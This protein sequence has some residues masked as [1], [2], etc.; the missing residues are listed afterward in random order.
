MPSLRSLLRQVAVTSLFAIALGQNVQDDWVSP[1]MPD[2]ST[3]VAVG[4]TF[5]IKWNMHLH[6]WFKDHAPGV[7]PENTDLWVE[8]FDLHLYH[9]Q[10]ASKSATPETLIC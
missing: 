6:S 2:N 4:D 3:S 7:D 9:K 5:T 8:D 1:A 10:I